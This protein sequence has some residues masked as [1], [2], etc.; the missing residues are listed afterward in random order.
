MNRTTKVEACM[1]KAWHLEVSLHN[2][3]LRL[4]QV[5]DGREGG[6][7][8]GMHTESSSS[9]QSRQL[10]TALST[11]NR[12]LGRLHASLNPREQELHCMQVL[13]SPVPQRFSLSC[14]PHLTSGHGSKAFSSPHAYVLHGRHCSV[15]CMHQ[16]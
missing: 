15:A 12:L 6:S 7:A 10:K 14:E 1:S 16:T 9:E 11:R 2:A 4:L 13:G 8:E 3:S 5:I